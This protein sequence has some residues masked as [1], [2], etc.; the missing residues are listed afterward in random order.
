MFGPPRHVPTPGD[1]AL[2]ERP[3]PGMD[4]RRPVGHRAGNRAYPQGSF[5]ETRSTW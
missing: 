3:D 4:N 5:I 1:R 2:G